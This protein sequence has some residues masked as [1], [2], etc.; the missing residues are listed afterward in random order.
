MVQH[1]KASKKEFTIIVIII[2]IIL[3][4]KILHMPHWQKN[5]YIYSVNS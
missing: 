1:L 2:I 4:T 3:F 5:I